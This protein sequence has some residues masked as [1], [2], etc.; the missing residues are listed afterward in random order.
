MVAVT[1]GQAWSA[2]AGAIAAYE[3]LAADGQLLSEGVTAARARHW[4]FNVAFVGGVL[5]TAAHLLD[6]LPKRVDPFTQALRVIR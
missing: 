4:S 3:V 5:V 6:G 1:A 2:L